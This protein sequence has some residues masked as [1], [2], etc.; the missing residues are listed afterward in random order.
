MKMIGLNCSCSYWVSFRSFNICFGLILPVV[1]QLPREEVK[2]KIFMD[3][4]K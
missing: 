1:N 2:N 3:E 4:K